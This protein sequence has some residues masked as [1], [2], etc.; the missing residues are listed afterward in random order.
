MS[1]GLGRAY[2]GDP[3]NQSNYDE[4]F[5]KKYSEWNS[6]KDGNTI[7]K[8]AQVFPKPSVL[9]S[10]ESENLKNQYYT[11]LPK[12]NQPPQQPAP[13]M[14]PMGVPPAG[15]PQPTIGL[16]NYL[17]PEQQARASEIQKNKIPEMGLQQAQQNFAGGGLPQS[18]NPSRFVLS[19]GEF[20]QSYYDNA[21]RN[22]QGGNDVLSN[23]RLAPGGMSNPQAAPQAL[24]PQGGA[25]VHGAVLPHNLSQQLEGPNSL[26]GQVG[27]GIDQ[28]QLMGQG[29]QVSTPNMYLDPSQAGAGQQEQV[30]P[31]EQAAEEQ[32]KQAII[33]I[34]SNPQAALLAENTAFSPAPAN[35]QI[36]YDSPEVIAG[37]V[38]DDPERS[39]A[40][41]DKMTK[42]QAA[43]TP[44]GS[45][46]ENTLQQ[47]T[48]R[49]NTNSDPNSP[50][51]AD[52]GSYSC[53]LTREP[54]GK[55]GFF[56]RFFA[57]LR[58]LLGIDTPENTLAVIQKQRQKD[59]E[60]MN[61]FA[62]QQQQQIQSQGVPGMQ[63]IQ[64][65][66]AMEP[67]MNSYIPPTEGHSQNF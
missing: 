39:T 43:S 44:A 41:F 26:G 23:N 28:S 60:T 14:P 2:N 67:S 25:G 31:N 12:M 34:L 13:Q 53:P 56:A 57:S 63:P 61:Y 4:E 20:D 49:P 40:K 19:N 6:L 47:A 58:M 64:P 38:K 30:D 48:I 37:A 46:V 66:Q 33:P 51:F 3:F 54:C 17:S 16:D 15:V 59:P 18:L 8:K 55:K 24:P 52:N 32:T 1:E 29:P 5:D 50:C 65:M 22:M 45:M 27:Q 7:N 42:A 35:Q 10:P 62:Q 21:L 9:G 36:N 11:G